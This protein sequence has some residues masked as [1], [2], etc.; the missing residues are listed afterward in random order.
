M[1]IAAILLQV[2][3]F[4]MWVSAANDPHTSVAVSDISSVKLLEVGGAHAPV[5]VG[6]GLKDLVYFPELVAGL[7]GVVPEPQLRV[8]TDSEDS[9]FFLVVDISSP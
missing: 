2:S 7:L 3:S 8:D 5:S 4:M 1:I 9:D 6:H